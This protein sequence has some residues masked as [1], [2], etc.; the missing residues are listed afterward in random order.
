MLSR[1]LI[2][3]LQ[4][5]LSILTVLPQSFKKYGQEVFFFNDKSQ[6]AKHYVRSILL[7]VFLISFTVWTSRLEMLLYFHLPHF[8]Q[9]VMVLLIS[10]IT[11][12]LAITLIPPIYLQRNID[13]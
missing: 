8:F 3:S 1:K 4:V 6:S 2:T 5:G 10:K 9:F 7:I 13:G 12:L 11:N